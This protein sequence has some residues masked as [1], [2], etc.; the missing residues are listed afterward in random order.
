[1]ALVPH[2]DVKGKLVAVSGH[3]VRDRLYD[4][5]HVETALSHVLGCGHTQHTR[6]VAAWVYDGNV[7]V[8]ADF[9]SWEL[10]GLG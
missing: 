4:R 2:V 1:M 8:G 9:F 5:T 3:L 7:W 10:C 6:A